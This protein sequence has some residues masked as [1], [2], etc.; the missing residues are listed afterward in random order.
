MG[1]KE[2][3]MSGLLLILFALVLVGGFVAYECL[4]GRV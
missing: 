2:E 3:V 1:P 4:R